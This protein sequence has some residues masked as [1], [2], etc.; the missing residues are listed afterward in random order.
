MNTETSKQVRE[1]IDNTYHTINNAAS[2]LMTAQ[3]QSNVL[4]E[5][6]QWAT[7]T[8]K[9]LEDACEVGRNDP[10]VHA[11]E[12]A[13]LVWLAEEVFELEMAISKTM[14]GIDFD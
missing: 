4:L 9:F 13:D 6:L 1:Y 2:Y 5:Y 10:S 7:A 12:Y 11:E 3:P 14:R 8:N